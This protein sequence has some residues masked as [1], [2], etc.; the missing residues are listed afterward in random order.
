MCGH[1]SRGEE[2]AFSVEPAYSMDFKK[3]V[4]DIS[5]YN[6]LLAASTKSGKVLLSK[7]DEHDGSFIFYSKL[8]YHDNAV[9]TTSFSP[10]GKLLLSA[11]FDS[12][13]RVWDVSDPVNPKSK[14]LL[15]MHETEVAAAK[16]DSSG[17]WIVTAD[18]EGEIIIWDT[19][20]WDY[21]Q[22]QSPRTSEDR[23]T[24]IVA[25]SKTP[26]TFFIGTRSGQI[27]VLDRVFG[28]W[29]LHEKEVAAEVTDV[30]S[31]PNGSHYFVTTRKNDLKIGTIYAWLPGNT[32][33]KAVL[34]IQGA[35]LHHPVIHPLDPNLVFFAGSDGYLHLWNFRTGKH[36]RFGEWHSERYPSSLAVSKPEGD[37]CFISAGD[38]SGGIQVWYHSLSFDEPK[39]IARSFQA[40]SE[41]PTVNTLQFHPQNARIFIS[42]TESSDKMDDAV[43]SWKIT[44][45]KSLGQLPPLTNTKGGG[46]Q[47][48]YCKGQY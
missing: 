17:T 23:V 10:N 36:V 34:K 37:I 25:A 18:W 6:S 22:V 1:T 2:R 28:R 31:A 4:W 19:E 27:F 9:S 29:Q 39:Q 11:S 38:S 41:M 21:R 24:S 44:E 13:A 12:T 16:F 7:V 45:T 8:V 42:A 3:A 48:G 35:A 14:R 30:I 5:L 32:L 33:P 43:K 47:R 26:N 15:N 46:S 20:T 40:Y